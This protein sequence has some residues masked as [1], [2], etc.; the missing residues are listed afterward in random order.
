MNPAYIKTCDGREGLPDGYP[1]PKE[2]TCNSS[3]GGSCCSCGG[4]LPNPHIHIGYNH[5]HDDFGWGGNICSEG[6]AGI[7][8]VFVEY[9]LSIHRHRHD[10]CPGHGCNR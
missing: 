10:L 8:Q 1:S 3:H 4:P 6:C 2:G 5:P 7:F 9:Q